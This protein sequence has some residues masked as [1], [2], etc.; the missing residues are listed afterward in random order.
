METY[1]YEIKSAEEVKKEE[2]Y[3]KLAIIAKT[4]NLTDYP[5]Q[6]Q[7]MPTLNG[8]IITTT[9]YKLIDALIK[10]KDFIMKEI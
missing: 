2:L 9:D 10:D 6:I 8:I 4:F 1:V 3:Q 5:R 7:L